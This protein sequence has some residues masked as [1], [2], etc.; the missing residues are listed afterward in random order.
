ME[1]PVIEW[2]AQKTHLFWNQ[3]LYLL[4]GLFV[5]LKLKGTILLQGVGQSHW[6]VEVHVR[7]LP[8]DIV[9]EHRVTTFQS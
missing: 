5:L 7:F 8:F 9:D 3:T 1:D 2:T 6:L 4:G